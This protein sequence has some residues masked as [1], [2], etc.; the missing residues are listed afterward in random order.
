MRSAL[1]YLLTV[2][3]LTTP[4]YTQTP[5]FV[6][7]PQTS[8]ISFFVKASVAL[9]GKFDKWSAVLTFKS[10]DVDTGALDI[11]I[12]AATVDTGSSMKNNKLKSE[13]F[14]DVR[15]NPVIRFRST[16]V[17]QTGPT[18]FDVPGEFTIRG[19]SKPQT[20]KLEVT[21]KGTGAGTIKGTMVF[22][23]KDYGMTSGIP[24]VKIADHVEVTVDLN[25][26][27][28]SGGSLIYKQ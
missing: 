24:F 20:L 11:K 6:T 16:K 15:N 13:D 8:S 12:Q 19:V 28:V 3:L 9:T 2:A 25:V 7:T 27:Q 4:G 23:R 22:D 10:R 26:K 1:L 18:S 5:V 17:V 14:F 21:G